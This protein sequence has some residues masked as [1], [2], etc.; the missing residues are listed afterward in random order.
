MMVIFSN[1]FIDTLAQE[2]ETWKGFADTLR[3]EDRSLFLQMLEQCYQYE[4]AINSK[5]EYYSAESFL[6]A[7]V[8]LQHKIIN[9][10]INNNKNN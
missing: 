8:F 2:I 5:G 9:I 7:L 3:G 4:R 10:L 1:D 6:M